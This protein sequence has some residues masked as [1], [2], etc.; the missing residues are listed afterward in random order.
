M[1]VANNY[2]EISAKI[3]PYKITKI[4]KPYKLI[5]HICALISPWIVMVINGD[6]KLTKMNTKCG[7]I[8]Q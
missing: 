4:N 6:K 2:G 8:Q 7:K 5:C 3:M 1:V